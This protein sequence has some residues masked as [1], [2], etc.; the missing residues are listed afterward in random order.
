MEWRDLLGVAWLRNEFNWFQITSDLF[1]FTPNLLQPFLEP[2]IWTRLEFTA[3]FD[4]MHAATWFRSMDALFKFL[5]TILRVPPI[6]LKVTLRITCARIQ[7]GFRLLM[8]S[9]AAR[10]FGSIT[11]VLANKIRCS[12]RNWRFIL[13]FFTFLSIIRLQITVIT[14][15]RIDFLQGLLWM[16]I[17]FLLFE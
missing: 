12:C 3:L 4:F 1:L 14:I 13:R 16:I 11:R 17:G 15:R 6:L 10:T 2:S 5:F 8:T 7:N 9:M